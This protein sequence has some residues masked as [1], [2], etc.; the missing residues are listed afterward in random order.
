M[1]SIGAINQLNVTEGETIMR[2]NSLFKKILFILCATAIAVVPVTS[3]SAQDGLVY[4]VTVTNITRGQQFTPILAATHA[5]GVRFFEL[6][7]AAGSELAMLAEEGNTAPMVGLLMATQGVGGIATSSGLLAPG[8]STT[9]QVQARGNANHI[10]LA[11]MLIP[12]NDAFMALDSVEL[13]RGN[14]TL[15]MFASVYDSGS[16]INDELCASIPGPFFIEC[17]GPG[18]GGMPQGGEE[19]YV[20]VHSG[21]HG[22]G[23]ISPAMRDWRNPV[24]KI[25]IR[26][27]N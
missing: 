24:A 26:R 16:E 14:G 12:T 5:N 19:G 13:P 2:Q 6:G 7:A 25:T 9:I 8:A 3:G 11:A 15:T 22:I 27:A 17:S 21:I 10:S 23:N 4:S 1:V 20:H 18:G